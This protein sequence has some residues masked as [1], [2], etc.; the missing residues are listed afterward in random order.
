[1]ALVKITASRDQVTCEPGT[2]A[3][4]AFDV[5]NAQDSAIRVGID[6]TAPPKMKAC[7]KVDGPAEVEL[8]PRGQQKLKA[9]IAIPANA[10]PSS[11]SFKL[12]VYDARRPEIAEESAA[13]AV[14]VQTKAAPLPPP[15]PNGK[16]KVNWP[17]IIG[18]IVGGVL[19]IGGI[20]TAVIMMGGDDVPKLVGMSLE[21]AEKTLTDAKLKL[22]TVTEEAAEEVESGH[23]IKQTPEAGESI[24]EDNTVNVVISPASNEVPRV[25]ALTVPAAEAKLS[26]AGFVPGEKTMTVTGQ[27]PGGTVTAQSP[28]AAARALP[29]TSVALTVEKMR[30]VVPGVQGQTV[31]VAVAALQSRGLTQGATQP[32]NTGAPALTVVNT[33]PAGGETVDAGTAVNLLVEGQKVSVPN[34]VS[35]PLSE[36]TTAIANAGLRLAPPISRDHRRPGGTIDTV[37]DQDPDGGT[38]VAP[39]SDVRLS[40]WA[41]ARVFDPRRAAELYVPAGGYTFAGA[42]D[43]RTRAR[44]VEG[45]IAPSTCKPGYVLRLAFKGDNVCVTMATR[46]QVLADNDAAKDRVE[47]N[48]ALLHHGP[49]TCKQGYVWREAREGDV[50]CVTPAVRAD[51]RKDNET[52]ASRAS[53]A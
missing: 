20:I 35:K 34:V 2:S 21:E 32:A 25:V 26:E 11:Q 31:P 48:P 43:H 33:D 16:K 37:S 36:A 18:A 8:P 52:A 39:G 4:V 14:K 7:V 46:E 6:V 5:V 27:S 38:P 40:V 23:V 17:L 10:E 12:R 44:T 45:S 3:D 42:R 15:P 24:P 28:E 19:L 53:G 9:T 47:T 13:I 22:G 29:G 49:T 51:T 41:E 1:M 50:V 30:V